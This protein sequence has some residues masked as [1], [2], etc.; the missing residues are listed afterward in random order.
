MRIARIW[1]SRRI[2]QQAGRLLS[3]HQAEVR[4]DRFLD[5]VACIIATH[6]QRRRVVLSL[7]PASL[8]VTVFEDSHPVCPV[9]N[10][11]DLPSAPKAL[12]EVR[13]FRATPNSNRVL[14]N[15][16]LPTNR[17]PALRRWAWEACSSAGHG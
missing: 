9:G 12:P 1:G 13:G 11:L 6:R 3:L 10:T 16:T 14:M 5:S 8:C 2:R 17:F 4:F 7:R 15:Y